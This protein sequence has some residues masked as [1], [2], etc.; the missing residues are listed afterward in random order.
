MVPEN[1]YEVTIGKGDIK[2]EGKD[3]T[4]VA[5]SYMVQLATRAAEELAEDGI[6]VEV[7]DLRTIKPLDKSLI[8][9]S[10]TKLADW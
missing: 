1:I 6:D 8:F 2:R 3:V 5:V 4:I 9:K 10:L 7:V